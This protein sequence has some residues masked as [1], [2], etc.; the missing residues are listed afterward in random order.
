MDVLCDIFKERNEYMGLLNKSN[1]TKTILTIGD[2]SKK[3]S[4]GIVGTEEWNMTPKQ[5]AF[6]DLLSDRVKN[7]ETYV[8]WE[9]W[10]ID[11]VP[12]LGLKYENKLN[13]IGHTYRKQYIFFISTANP[14]GSTTTYKVSISFDHKKIEDM[15]LREYQQGH[16]KNGKWYSEIVSGNFKKYDHGTAK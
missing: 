14:D 10:T 4:I 16:I 12:T 3:V 5:K 8:L 15:Q 7:L 9:E 1:K 11:N 6:C 2:I 13:V